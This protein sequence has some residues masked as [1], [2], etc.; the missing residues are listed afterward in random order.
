[1]K[2]RFI[3]FGM[4][5]VVEKDVERMI[6]NYN[7]VDYSMSI[8]EEVAVGDMIN[9]NNH[10]V[11]NNTIYSEFDYHYNNLTKDNNSKVNSLLDAFATKGND[12]SYKTYMFDFFRREELRKEIEKEY[13]SSKHKEPYV[14]ILE[15]FVKIAK[16]E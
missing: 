8:K 13:I 16:G 2:T 6:V 4:G 9:L 14:F 12:Y 3:E 11:E 7:G 5:I 15:E 10:F 1:M